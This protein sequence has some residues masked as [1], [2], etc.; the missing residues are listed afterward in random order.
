MA[1]EPERQDLDPTDAYVYLGVGG[2]VGAVL[3]LH[4]LFYVG[5]WWQPLYNALRE[6]QRVALWKPGVVLASVLAGLAVMFV[7]C[8]AARKYERADA[9][10]RRILYGYNSVL[11]LLLVGILLLIGNLGV[12]MWA[13]P[14]LDATE[15]NFHSLSDVTQKFVTE[16]DR[17]VHVYVI[18]PANY[19]VRANTI[20]VVTQMHELNPRY[21]V[22]EEVSPQLNRGRIT[23]LNKR[24]PQFTD[25]GLIVAYGDKEDAYSFISASEL[26]NT[27]FD[28][29]GRTQ[30][31]RAFNGEV[32]L[33]QEL[34]FLAENKKQPVV[35]FT[36]G[37]GEPEEAAPGDEGMA[38]LRVKL[39]QAK[40]DARTLKFTDDLDPNSAV[41]PADADVVV[42]AGPT[43]PLGPALSAL[44]KYMDP[45]DPAK[46]KGKLIVLLG[47]T[48][49]DRARQPDAKNRAGRLPALL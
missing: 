39:L 12:R 9:N 47:P 43:R 16:L 11:T 7:S 4:P 25:L 48:P 34:M 24:F 36:Q 32:Q 46:P 45:L 29:M 40:I 22:Y 20:S 15:G 27:D 18:L 19:E 13:P 42:V 23:E 1:T 41:V 44:R 38:S 10:L 17:P 6:G 30:T 21:F 35:Y 37:H 26:E 14:F 3:L 2:L 5:W 33:L 31:G 49:G 28:P 8:Q